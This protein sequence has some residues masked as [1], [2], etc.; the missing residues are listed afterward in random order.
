MNLSSI[1]GMVGPVSFF[2]TIRNVNG[3]TSDF[4]KGPSTFA[5]C[6]YMH[7]SG[8]VTGKSAVGAPASAST[9]QRD[10]APL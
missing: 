3:S 4:A 1:V 8:L 7:L 6:L 9:L 2:W 10:C 5:V